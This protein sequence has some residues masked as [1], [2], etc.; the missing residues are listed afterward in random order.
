MTTDTPTVIKTIRPGYGFWRTDKY[1]IGGDFDRA[2]PEG[3]RIVKVLR[4]FPAFHNCTEEG[5]TDDGR[6]V[7]YGIDTLAK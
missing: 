1:P 4:T 2:G 3:V 7:A 6:K 5:L